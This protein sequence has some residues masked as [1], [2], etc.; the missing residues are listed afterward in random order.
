MPSCLLSLLAVGRELQESWLVA[1]RPEVLG[2]Q[3]VPAQAQEVQEVGVAQ[4]L[5]RVPGRGQPLVLEELAEAEV[6]Y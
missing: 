5:R 3:E 1:R 2:V 4:P 6:H